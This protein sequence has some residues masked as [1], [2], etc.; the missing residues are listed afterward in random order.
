M[1]YNNHTMEYGDARGVFGPHFLDCCMW[2]KLRVANCDD[3]AIGTDGEDMSEP[4]R[5][6]RWIGLWEFQVNGLDIALRQQRHL[7]G[8]LHYLWV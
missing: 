8:P 3:E 4:F 6:R 2:S 5:Y 7:H 1:T